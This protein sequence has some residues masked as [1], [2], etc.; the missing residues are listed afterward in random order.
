MFDSWRL[1]DGYTFRSFETTVERDHRRAEQGKQGHGFP[2]EEEVAYMQSEVIPAN[3]SGPGVLADIVSK[4]GPAAG[5]CPA[6]PPGVRTWHSYRPLK[7]ATVSS[8]TAPAHPRP[9]MRSIG[10]PVP[11]T[12]APNGYGFSW[13]TAAPW[14]ASIRTITPVVRRIMR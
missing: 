11:V 13:A 7:W 10:W 4:N 12:F 2:G 3:T 1:L 6:N 5:G 9:G 14:Q 8:H